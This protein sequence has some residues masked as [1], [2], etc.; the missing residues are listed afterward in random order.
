MNKLRRL[1]WIILIVGVLWDLSYHTLLAIA[2]TALPPV[3]DVLGNMGHG[4]TLGGI[5]LVIL[6]Y[7]YKQN[8]L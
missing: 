3:V 6:S 8:R 7:I 1:G 4:I 5:V 2:T